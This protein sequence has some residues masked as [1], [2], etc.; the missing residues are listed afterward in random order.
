MS[1]VIFICSLVL[2]F[3]LTK[4]GYGYD[5]WLFWIVLVCYST[6][7]VVSFIE[8]RSSIKRDKSLKQ[9]RDKWKQLAIETQRSNDE[10]IKASDKL[11]KLNGELIALCK[12]Y[13][14]KLEVKGEGN[15]KEIS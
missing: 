7:C 1:I 14:E 8:G 3:S 15:E 2:S 5:S 10:L 11:A 9:S 6:A 4:E 13:Q 12:T